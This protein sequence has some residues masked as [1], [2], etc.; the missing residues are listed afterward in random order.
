MSKRLPLS[1]EKIASLRVISKEELARHK[2]ASD[3]W[4]ALYGLVLDVT[5][6][7]DVHPGTDLILEGAG[8]DATSLFEEMMHS[9]AARMIAA[10]Y[11][12]GR[13]Q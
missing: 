8:K 2:K 12:I 1:D 9:D 3:C 7:V 13:L 4:L 6:Y 5:E 11:V 10:G